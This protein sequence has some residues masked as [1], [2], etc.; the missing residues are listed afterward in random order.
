MG[1]APSLGA[2][3]EGQGPRCAPVATRT[4][5]PLHPCPHS[6]RRRHPTIQR[7]PNLTEV[8]DSHSHQLS[9]LPAHPTDTPQRRSTHAGVAQGKGFLGSAKARGDGLRMARTLRR[10][11]GS[12]ALVR[13]VIVLLV[14]L[15]T[16]GN[17]LHSSTTPA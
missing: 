14:C 6:H 13:K 12:P 15:R 16:L 5:L 11:V 4:S 1:L 8:V 9:A 2:E 10:I 7:R 3:V 17:A